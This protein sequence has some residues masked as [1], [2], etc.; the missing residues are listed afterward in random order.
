V[1]C[2]IA[3]THA[4][5]RATTI[6]KTQL[7]QGGQ[8]ATSQDKKGGGCPLTNATASPSDLK[9]TVTIKDHAAMDVHIRWQEVQMAKQC[10][11][12]VGAQAP[13]GGPVVVASG[14]KTLAAGQSWSMSYDTATDNVI[15]SAYSDANKAPYC[16]EN[17][18]LDAS[19]G[20]LTL[21][22]TGTLFGNHCTFS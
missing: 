22:F 10:G 9:Q 3:S 18:T 21:T 20:E 5:V 12:T 14:T 11:R 19:K 4:Q 15:V 13:N 1:L 8:T 7:P 16:W 6:D 2:G 17:Q